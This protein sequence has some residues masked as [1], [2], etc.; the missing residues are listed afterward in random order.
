MVHR[1]DVG[2][3][4]FDWR[5]ELRT[6]AGAQGTGF[7]QASYNLDRAPPHQRGQS[8]HCSKSLR[9]LVMYSYSTSVMAEL[10]AAFSRLGVRPLYSP[11]TCQPHSLHT[12]ESLS[13]S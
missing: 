4:L 8:E 9:R 2:S 12:L 5:P 11:R 1:S 7:F 6:S 10:G 13:L 3:V